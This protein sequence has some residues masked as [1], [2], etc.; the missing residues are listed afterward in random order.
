MKCKPGPKLKRT[1]STNSQ[2]N[3]MKPLLI[4]WTHKLSETP[5]ANHS[6]S[7]FFL[8]L[9]SQI[10]HLPLPASHSRLHFRWTIQKGIVEWHRSM[11]RSEPDHWW[12][13]PRRQGNLDQF[14]ELFCFESQKSRQMQNPSTLSPTHPHVIRQ[15][16]TAKTS[17]FEAVHEHQRLARQWTVE[18]CSFVFELNFLGF[19]FF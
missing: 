9:T 12:Q 15:N 6:S 3:P 5:I 14:Q 16:R 2:A 17:R 8:C 19:Y 11:P 10:A 18:I 1:T 4:L 7:P 13:L